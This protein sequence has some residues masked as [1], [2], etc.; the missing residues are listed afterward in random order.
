MYALRTYFSVC[1]GQGYE[2]DKDV[3]SDVEPEEQVEEEQEIDIG[4]SLTDLDEKIDE[5]VQ[6]Y[7]NI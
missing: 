2:S 1:S 4:G 6:G 3:E 7:Y 5:R